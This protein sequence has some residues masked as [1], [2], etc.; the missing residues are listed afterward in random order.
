MIDEKEMRERYEAV[1]NGI[2][3]VRLESL[4]VDAVTVTDLY[5]YARGEIELDDVLCHLRERVAAGAFHDPPET[6]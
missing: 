3:T 6:P 4:D 5:R 1:A 2:A